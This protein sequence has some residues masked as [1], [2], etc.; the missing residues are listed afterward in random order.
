M[1]VLFVK[2]IEWVCQI[3]LFSIMLKKRTEAKKRKFNRKEEIS[4]PRKTYLWSANDFKECLHQFSLI[5]LGFLLF[6]FQFLCGNKKLLWLVFD[7]KDFV[8]CNDLRVHTWTGLCWNELCFV[9]KVYVNQINSDNLMISASAYPN[10]CTVTIN[11]CR[12]E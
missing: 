9:T 12:Q 7:T 10:L 8:I 3:F 4:K 2:V 6:I 1:L 11:L 5:F